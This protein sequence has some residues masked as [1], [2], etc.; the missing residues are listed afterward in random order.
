MAAKK[1]KNRVDVD[2]IIPTELTES[3]LLELGRDHAA[4][5]NALDLMEED[6]AAK[7]KKMK[8]ERENLEEKERDQ[9]TAISTG[10]QSRPVSCYRERDFEKG[11]ATIRRKDNDSVVRTEKLTDDERQTDLEDRARGAKAESSKTGRE[12]HHGEQ[13]DPADERA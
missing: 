9:R 12:D 1:P 10:K 11:I 4:S 3:E 13:G 2:E 8:L 7:K 6:H 5:L